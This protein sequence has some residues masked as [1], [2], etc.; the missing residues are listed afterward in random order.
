MKRREKR[1]GEKG[2]KCDLER[3]SKKSGVRQ[4]KGSQLEEEEREEKGR[5]GKEARR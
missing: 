5:E 3:R 2:R 1:R 4:G